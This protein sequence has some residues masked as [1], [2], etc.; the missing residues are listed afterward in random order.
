M[1]GRPVPVVEVVVGALALA[2][3]APATAR[4]DARPGA[5]VRVEQRPPSASIVIGK[6][7]AAVELELF[8]RPGVRSAGAS[9]DR[10]LALYRAHPYRVRLRVRVQSMAA[11]VR[12]PEA[13]LEAAAQ[14]RFLELERLIRPPGAAAGAASE[15]DLLDAARRAGLD[16]AALTRA[17]A[18]GQHAAALRENDAWW[19]RVIGRSGR[20]ARLGGAMLP[21][22]LGQVP[23]ETL[24]ASYQAAYARAQRGAPPKSPQATDPERAARRGALDERLRGGARPAEQRARTALDLRGW[25]A[26][27]ASADGSVVLA[28]NLRRGAC[29]SAIRIANQL[30]PAYGGAINLVWVP[31]FDPRAPDALGTGLFHDAARCAHRQGLGWEWVT[32][33]AAAPATRRRAGAP[34]TL[35]RG[36]ADRTW[37]E[38]ERL[39]AVVPVDR[40]ALSRCVAVVAGASARFVGAAI[41]AGVVASPSMLIGDRVLPG[42]A[43]DPWSLARALDEV[44]R[45][46]LLRRWSA[47]PG[48]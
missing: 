26:T 43:A 40:A 35:A 34:R 11:S 8:Y 41:G 37:D 25:P 44:S 6:P 42:G 14:G 33:A 38:I 36:G 12:L 17:W 3:A 48:P 7:T 18:R 20:D 10:A 45:P 31:W 13:L 28:C 5:V 23:A 39:A 27:T 1:R 46:G 21:S 24:E 16:A 2:L 22:T 15:A 9:L 47:R 32:A 19:H 4:A 30:L 29:A